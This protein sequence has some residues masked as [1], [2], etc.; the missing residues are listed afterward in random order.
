MFVHHVLYTKGATCQIFYNIYDMPHEDPYGVCWTPSVSYSWSEAEVARLDRCR[1]AAT[2]PPAQARGLLQGFPR[3]RR[4]WRLPEAHRFPRRRSCKSHPLDQLGSDILRHGASPWPW[5][6]LVSV[7]G[8]GSHAHAPLCMKLAKAQ[9]ILRH[10]LRYTVSCRPWKNAND[11]ADVEGLICCCCF[12][13]SAAKLIV[14]LPRASLSN[15]HR[16]SS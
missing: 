11:N 7:R 3:P 9:H 13:A 6:E 15:N 8:H 10:I 14:L 12:L 2:G 5:H 1:C 16:L 4:A